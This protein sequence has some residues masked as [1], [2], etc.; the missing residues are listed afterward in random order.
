M[1]AMDVTASKGSVDI[2]IKLQPA[3]QPITPGQA[4][5]VSIEGK[6]W[7]KY[8]VPSDVLAQGDHGL[9]ETLRIIYPQY[10]GCSDLELA[11]TIATSKDLQLSLSNWKTSAAAKKGV[12]FPMP[13]DVP[14]PVLDKGPL[15]KPAVGG[16]TTGTAA[17]S[18]PPGG[19]ATKKQWVEV[20]GLGGGKDKYY[21]MTTPDGAMTV[22][23]LHVYKA[24]DPRLKTSDG[25][26]DPKV[27]QNTAFFNLAKQLYG[28]SIAELE[29]LMATHPEL[30]TAHDKFMVGGD[31]KF[32]AKDK[33]VPAKPEKKDAASAK[34]GAG[35]TG[36]A[37][38]A[39]ATT[40]KSFK[41]SGQVTINYPVAGWQNKTGTYAVSKAGDTITVHGLSIKKNE[42]WSAADN[43]TA[44]YY[45]MEQTYGL[46]A[47]QV[48]YAIAHNPAVSKAH[49]AFTTGLKEGGSLDLKL[50]ATLEVS[51]APAK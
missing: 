39:P 31:V 8:S 21:V 41:A 9:C 6:T 48:D 16:A 50:P 22:K 40:T 36:A 26:I 30:K 11:K 15:A 14:A 23:D 19:A 45:F 25:V 10:A 38:A 35:A 27:G 2:G 4:T 49:W 42:K 43:N 18:L 13:G 20:D 7:I 17:P 46:S 29:G 24:D 37:G 34:P 1:A 28:A 12:L 47:K 51:A 32:P 44:F 3:G 5:T 33:L